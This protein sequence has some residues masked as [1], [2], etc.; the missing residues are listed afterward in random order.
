MPVWYAH[1][2]PRSAT[3]DQPCRP[4]RSIH[5]TN[6]M[7]LLVAA[8]AT[9]CSFVIAAGQGSPGVD[10]RTIATGASRVDIEQAIGAPVSS[11]TDADGQQINTYLIRAWRPPSQERG[12][13]NLALDVI[14]LGL[15]ELVGTPNELILDPVR[16]QRELTL[17]FDENGR[18]VRMIPPLAER[19]ALGPWTSP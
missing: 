17:T 3:R 10:L 4:G 16:R 15:W 12:L 2:H 13:T 19:D 1:A 11:S 8:L 9:G 14:T 18:V 5:R 7:L 6:G